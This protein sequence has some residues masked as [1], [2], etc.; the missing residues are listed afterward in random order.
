MTSGNSNKYHFLEGGG[1]MGALTRA[2]DWSSTPLGSVDDWPQT[3]KAIVGVILHSD[4]PMF[5]WWGDDMI[6]FYNDAYRPSLGDN[7]KHP[8]ALGQ[9]AI[10]CWPE[11]WDVIFPLINQVRTDNKSFF[12]EDQL[13][14]IYRNGKLD[15]VY[16]TFSYSSVIGESGSTDGVLV[17]CNETTSKVRMMQELKQSKSLLLA[18]ESNLLSIIRQAPVAMAILT[19]PQHV[20]EIAN[21]K[22]YELWG[23]PKEEMLG[24]PVFEVLVDA[25]YEGFEDILNSAYLTGETYVAYGAPVTLFRDGG[26][27]V[28]Y[29]HFMYEPFREP[30]GSISGMMVVATDVTH[31]LLARRKLEQ[32]EY[33]VRSIIE[34]APFPIGIYVGRE[35]RIK[36]LNQSIIKAWG[37]GHDLIG[38]TYYEVLP[39]LESQGIFPKLDRVFTTGEP[40]HARNQRVDIVVDGKLGSY[41]FN[42]SFTPLLDQHGKVYGVLNTAAEVTDLNIAKLQIEQSE[43]N[44]RSMLRQAPVAMCIMLGKDHIIDVANDLIIELWGRPV[45]SVLN[46]PVA[47]VLSESEREGLMAIID[48]VYRTGCSYRAIARPVVR[49]RKDREQVVYQDF[50]YEP[51]KDADGTIL[52]V[53]AIAIDVTEQVL[54]RQKIEEVVAER[55]SDLQKSN[56]ELSQFA[57][58]ASHDLQEPARKISTFIGMVSKS[59]DGKIDERTSSYLGKI[60]TSSTRMLAL[61]RDVLSISQLSTVRY[62]PETVDLEKV[63]EEVWREFEL[64]VEQR[65][66]TREGDTLPVVRAIPVQMGQLFGNLLSN[67]LKFAKPDAPLRIHISVKAVDSSDLDLAVHRNG[68]RRYFKITFSDNGIGF[69]QNNAHQIFDIFQR[70]HSRSEYE[71]TGIGLAMCKKIVDNHGGQIFAHGEPGV[72]ATFT[73]ILPE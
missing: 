71:G 37:K 54:A 14:P 18:R 43:Q 72:G 49:W 70:L 48:Q 26:K 13:I 68:P 36:M 23:K 51:Y 11:I 34:S 17:V 8:T 5:L 16:W 33:E 62:P 42:Y 27:A 12:L 19:G 31:E 29:V 24:K 28:S 46:Q 45:E 3:L 52:G 35:M 1:E 47:A 44:F 4:F 39:E 2:Y 55:T 57:Y 56:A 7:G 65:Q 58:I 61:I 10:E 60:K 25:R 73:V 53:L 15:E 64:L 30:D 6:Q 67:A 40:Y 66:A 21:D 32:S 63:F 22:M 69:S 38:K 20:V 41:Y 9:R 59:L 50:V